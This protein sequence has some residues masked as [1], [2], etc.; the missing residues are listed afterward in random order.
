M[1]YCPKCGFILSSNISICSHCHTKIINQDIEQL[2]LSVTFEVKENNHQEKNSSRT[3]KLSLKLLT[4]IT[5]SI[6]LTFTAI[7]LFI[8]F[9]RE[10]SK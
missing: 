8:L 4:L 9:L 6:F 2:D 7:I 5:S 10:L 3:K 1:K